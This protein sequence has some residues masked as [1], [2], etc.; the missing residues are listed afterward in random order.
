MGR[1]DGRIGLTI[2]I[3]DFVKCKELLVFDTFLVRVVNLVVN[4]GLLSSTSLPLTSLGR[5][6]WDMFFLSFCL[7][8]PK[9]SRSDS[10]SEDSS[11]DSV[12]VDVPQFPE[13]DASQ[14]L[15]C[16]ARTAC[17]LLRRSM[18]SLSVRRTTCF[19]GCGDDEV[20]TVLD[21]V[22]AIGALQMLPKL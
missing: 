4:L 15:R 3:H 20:Y 12:F 10:S 7:E 1:R 5:R 17:R 11:P 9:E 21:L 18:A 19:D 16:S 22:S 14:S 2:W 13:E 8:A 6:P